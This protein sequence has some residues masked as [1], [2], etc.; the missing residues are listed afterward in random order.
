MNTALTDKIIGLEGAVESTIADRM[1]DQATVKDAADLTGYEAAT[2]DLALS[3]APTA[4]GLT[5]RLDL[6]DPKEDDE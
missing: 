2:S 6:S 5:E 1:T 4:F 3:V